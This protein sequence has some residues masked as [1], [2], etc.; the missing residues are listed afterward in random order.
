MQ[1]VYSTS[2]IDWASRLRIFTSLQRCSWC[3]LHPKWTGPVVWGFLPL[4]RNAVGVFYIPSGQGHSFEDSYPSAEMQ[5][6]YSTSQMDWASRLR[7][8]TSLQRC[9]RC[10]LHPQWTGPVVWGFLPLG[11]NAVGVFYIPNRLGQSFED[12]YLSAEMQSVYST[13][14][15]DWASRLRIFTSLQKCSWCILHPKWTGPVVWGFLPLGRNAVGVFY[16]PSGQGHSFEDS[17]PSAEMQ[18]VYSTSQMDWA[19]R[20]RIFTSLQRC[21]RCILHPQWTGP[22]VWGFLPLG[23]NAVGVFYIPNRLGQSFEDFYLSAEMQSVYSTSPIDWASRL[24][25]FYLSAEMQSVYSTSPMDWASR[26]WI[27]TSLQKCSRCILHPQW[28]GPVVCG[29]LPLGR[30][31]VGVFYISNGLGQSFEDFYLSAEMQSVYS[32]SPMD[33]ASRLRI[34]TSLQRCSRCILHPQWT[35]PVVWLFLPLCRNAVGV[36]YIPNGLG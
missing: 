10:I 28:T 33:W 2:P 17:Y 12:F 35:G 27:F 29:F 22:V 19:S 21:S 14:P 30:N 20:L 6:V 8:F 16:I 1:L 18:L 34:F 31:A 11:K 32:T 5:L 4:G 24:V 26:L 9:S 13:S 36:F 25:D 15:I 23:K 7:I 3:I